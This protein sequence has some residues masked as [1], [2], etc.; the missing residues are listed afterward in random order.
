MTQR[1]PDPPPYLGE[2]TRQ[3]VQRKLPYYLLGLALGCVLVG[4]IM[5]IKQM[6]SSPSPTSPASSSPG[7]SSP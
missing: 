2:T 7:Q 1:P 6:S 4:I 3:S 5:M